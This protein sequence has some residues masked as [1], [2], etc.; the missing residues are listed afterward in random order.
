MAR[1]TLQTIAD[2]LG[3]SRMTVSNAFSRP[4]QLSSDLRAQVLAVAERLGYVGPNPAARGLARGT[5]GNIGL[6]LS[7]SL[8]YALTDHVAVAF[9]AA[10]ADELGPTGRA[11]TLLPSVNDADFVPARDI[12]LDGAVIYS[13]IPDSPDVR[14][15][16]RRKLPLVF[17]DNIGPRGYPSVTIDDQGGA[18]DA[19]QHLIDLGHRNIAIVTNGVEGEFGVV[20]DIP[21]RVASF[22]ERERLHGWTGAL[23]RAGITPLLIRTKHGDPVNA[24]LAAG[25]QL[26]DQVPHP[27]GVLCFSDALATG[28]LRAARTAGLSVPADVSIVGF[29]DSPLARQLDPDLTTVRQDVTAKGRAAAAALIQQIAPV[30]KTRTKKRVSLPTELVVRGS[31][32]PAPS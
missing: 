9:L 12:A 28:V 6:L 18:R 32:G 19:A 24:G 25:E 23:D 5:V 3:V 26:F 15:L 1:V 22:P 17:V 11:L 7:E 31:T 10:I 16:E 13:C 8:N 20:T 14:W 30:A 4:D 27:T 2:A 29:D 21:D